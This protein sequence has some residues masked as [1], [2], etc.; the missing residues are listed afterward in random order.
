[1]ASLQ[2]TAIFMYAAK[3][4][5]ILCKGNEKVNVMI[6]KFINKFNSDSEIR[7]YNFF[8]NGEKIETDTYEQSIEKTKFGELETFVITVEK[9]IKI[10]KCPQCNYYDCVVSLLNYQTI[11]YN[12]EHYHLQISSYYNYFQ[13]QI[14]FPERILCSDEKCK[15]MEKWTLIFLCASLVPNY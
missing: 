6:Q 15:K 5:Q 2:K 13:D 4:I 7:D 11:F 10:I 14:Y 9:N 12:C 8:Y 1:M 3:P